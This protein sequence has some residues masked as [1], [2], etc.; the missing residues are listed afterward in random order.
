MITTIR[1]IEKI[2]GVIENRINRCDKRDGTFTQG[3]D[4]S[5]I[6]AK[7]RWNSMKKLKDILKM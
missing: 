1:Q 6:L 3:I 5:K 4:V 7:N 2:F